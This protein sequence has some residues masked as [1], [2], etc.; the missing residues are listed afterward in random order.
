MATLHD[1][2]I[3]NIHL[4]TL[5]TRN[6]FFS[7]VA[8]WE[9]RAWKISDTIKDPLPKPPSSPPTSSIA[10]HRADFAS[11]CRPRA[12][13]ASLSSDLLG[14]R[15]TYT[16]A[17]ASGWAAPPNFDYSKA[18]LLFLVFWFLQLIYARSLFCFI[19]HATADRK[20][21]RAAFNL[22]IQWPIYFTRT[23]NL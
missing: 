15:Q 7:R 4:F 17:V 16:S 2:L 10:R 21:H 8:S 14:D 1:D 19:L 18:S 5:R 6:T 22:H 20:W 11:L 13:F 9:S 3:F 23:V 12:D